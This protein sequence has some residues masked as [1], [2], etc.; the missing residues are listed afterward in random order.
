MMISQIQFTATPLPPIKPHF[1]Q[2]KREVLPVLPQV[3]GITRRNFLMVLFALIAS[4]CRALKRDDYAVLF[5]G[6]T[7]VML[8]RSKEKINE[9]L[10]R[11]PAGK[12][13][14][15]QQ[16]AYADHYEL[17]EGGLA[18]NAEN[19][20]KIY[21]YLIT[22][23]QNSVTRPNSLDS[24]PLSPETS[25]KIAPRIFYGPLENIQQFQLTSA[26]QER[27][28]DSP[29]MSLRAEYAKTKEQI[30]FWLPPF[31]YLGDPR[32]TREIAFENMDSDQRPKVFSF[33]KLKKYQY[34]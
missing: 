23:P 12:I 8:Y 24:L 26:S 11:I 22:I 32:D 29:K 4:A 9:A 13:Q 19:P 31:P 34:P 33:V 20:E 16:K 5:P 7:D 18:L 3:Q 15:I 1:A 2:N 28:E 6:K 30:L 17:W 25:Q 10:N 21:F 14:E 27:D